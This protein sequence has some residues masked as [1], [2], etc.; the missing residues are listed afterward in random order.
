MKNGH[1]NLFSIAEPLVGLPHID[2]YAGAWA[3]YEPAFNLLLG[4]AKNINV[5]LH[6]EKVQSA[7]GQAAIAAQSSS[8]VAVRGSGIGVIEIVGPMQKHV[9]SFSSGTS[10]VHARRQLRAAMDDSIA[11]V[12]IHF[13]TPGGTVAGT[14]D[15]A[16]DIAALAKKK[17]VY[18]HAPDLCASA[19]MWAAANCT[20]FFAGPSALIGSIGVFN[21]IYDLSQMAEKEGVEVHVVRFGAFKGSATPGTKITEEQLAEYQRIIDAYGDD[22]V[23]AIAKGRGMTK[24]EAKQL[25]DGRV[26]KGQ[27][28]VDL[29]LIDGVQSMDA[30]FSQL[31]EATKKPSGSSNKKAEARATLSGSKPMSTENS[32]EAASE[33]TL[34]A[35]LKSFTPTIKQLKAACPGASDSFLLEQVE[36]GAS[37]EDATKAHNVTLAAENAKLKADLAAKET[38]AKE[39][40]EGAEPPKVKKGNPALADAATATDDDSTGDARETWDAKIAET[41]QSRSISRPEAAVIV[42]RKHPELRAALCGVDKLK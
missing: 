25:A 15:L 26:H 39:K 2:Q 17:P 14:H 10:T 16:A 38:A 18:G 11:G 24:A 40:V 21:V 34:V 3:M 12:L 29:K 1:D 13:D 4:H 5:Q 6:M 20:K 28:A 9:S 32:R 19:G 42:G 36:L 7:E 37:L 35:E 27:E 30:T 8:E 22:F 33:G 23:S 41:M 31:I